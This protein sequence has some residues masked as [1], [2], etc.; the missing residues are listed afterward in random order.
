MAHCVLSYYM[1]K[2]L[3][4]PRY[5]V[6]RCQVMCDT[7]DDITQTSVILCGS[8]RSLF[9]PVFASDDTIHSLTASEGSYC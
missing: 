6:Y 8:P 7:Y 1:T 3:S 2:S 5:R 9:Q 4:G